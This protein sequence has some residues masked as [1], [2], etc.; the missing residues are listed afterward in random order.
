MKRSRYLLEQA[1]PIPQP[2]SLL[3]VKM[4]CGKEALAKVLWVGYGAGRGGGI[5]ESLRIEWLPATGEYIRGYKM[6]WGTRQEGIESTL[7]YPSDPAHSM[8]GTVQLGDYR[9]VRRY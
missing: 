2:N 5:A 4:P 8:Y 3:A 7:P 1:E 9:E 6:V